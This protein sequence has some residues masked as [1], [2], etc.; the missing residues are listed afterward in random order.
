MLIPNHYHQYH[1]MIDHLI[2]ENGGFW[3]GEAIEKGKDRYGNHKQS[4]EYICVNRN[5]Y[6]VI[7]LYFKIVN[8]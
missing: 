1:L 2:Q 8:T 7:D 3:D 5:F 4:L 6:V